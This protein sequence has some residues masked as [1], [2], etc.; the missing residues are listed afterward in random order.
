[1]KKPTR[2][3][4]FVIRRRTHLGIIMKL[5][6][7]YEVPI[8]QLIRIQKLIRNHVS[9]F[10]PRPPTHSNT[11]EVKGVLWLENMKLKRW[12]PGYY[13]TTHTS[14]RNG[15]TAAQQAAKMKCQQTYLKPK[16]TP[17][18]A[19]P[20]SPSKPNLNI[21]HSWRRLTQHATRPKIS[22]AEQRFCRN[23]CRVTSLA[24]SNP[25]HSDGFVI[26][27]LGN[28]YA[29]LFRRNFPTN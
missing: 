13:L 14:C 17:S 8:S 9:T 26:C 1:M 10:S 4:P 28:V 12:V 25:R 5:H 7:Y 20:N 21:W 29:R 2:M 6:D 19:S 18:S 16:S 15:D 27:Q 24:N 3:I 23:S 22:P 11:T